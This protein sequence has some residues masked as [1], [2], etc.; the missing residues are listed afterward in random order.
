VKEALGFGNSEVP[1][2]P[3]QSEQLSF[4]AAYS[5]KSAEREIET[6]DEQ[7]FLSRLASMALD[8]PSTGGGT[9]GG[10]QSPRSGGNAAGAAKNPGDNNN[11]MLANFFSSLMTKDIRKLISSI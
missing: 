10:T 5:S 8:G 3:Q 1:M 4:T 2:L 7:S 9:G 11:T 6:E